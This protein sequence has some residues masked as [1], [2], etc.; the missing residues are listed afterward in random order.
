MLKETY[1]FLIS[2]IEDIKNKTLAVAYS[3]GIDSQVLLNIAY[4]LKDELSF[5]LII[6]HV[7]YNLRGEDS[8]N[9]ELFARD[10]AKKYNIEIY[11][12]EI[13]P[14]S[15]NGKNIQLEARNDRYNFFEE[16]HNKKIYDYLLIAHNKDDLAETIIYRMIKGAGTN[17]Y[18]S[19]RDK[20]GYILRPILNFYRKDIEA[21]ARNNNLEHRE[22][23]SNKKNYYS[24]NKIRNLIIP[25]LEEINTNAK[26][27]I[28]RFAKRSYEE[29]YILRKK[30]NKLYKKNIY[31]KNTKLNIEKIKNT[32]ELFIKK[33]IVKFLAKN[34]IEI[35][36]K[37][38]SEILKVIKSDKPNIKLRLDNFYLIKEYNYINIKAIEKKLDNTKTNNFIRIEKDGI[39]NFLNKK[40]EIKTVLN[41]NINYKDNIYIKADY[42]LIIRNKKESD[43]I[44]A[45]PNGNKKYLRKI[46]IDLKIPL[47]ERERV[48]II[49]S[50]NDDILALYLE[51]YGL[52]RI[53]KNAAVNKD[54][55]YILEINVYYDKE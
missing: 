17:V 34:N 19:L 28:I 45:Y 25:M 42:P 24:R 39:Y 53:S 50:E 33:I 29:T 6:I 9:D 2:N 30:I 5:D 26:N 13:K 37:R 46:F 41:K 18:K 49:T 52:N 48:P 23:V 15:Y 8:T 21:Y 10:M 47:Y 22:D 1:N 38:V 54:D 55:E 36:E 11:V 43:F 20:K 7:N 51:P 35:T 44:N 40:I 4:R 27:N 12:K 32:N 3:G 31:K 14:N 16:L